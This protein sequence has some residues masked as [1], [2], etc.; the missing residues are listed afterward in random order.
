MCWEGR[1]EGPGGRGDMGTKTVAFHVNRGEDS[2]GTWGLWWRWTFESR[3]KAF[4][5]CPGGFASQPFIIQTQDLQG[6]LFVQVFPKKSMTVYG[7][8]GNCLQFS[9][10]TGGLF[11]QWLL[12]LYESS[13]IKT[14]ITLYSYGA[15][16]LRKPHSFSPAKSYFERRGSIMQDVARGHLSACQR[17]LTSGSLKQLR[18]LVKP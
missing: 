4:H 10:R 3:T 13:I 17:S 11:S 5:C 8:R 6:N 9:K 16:F 7:L 14:F 1:G 12:L 15:A 18:V 2:L